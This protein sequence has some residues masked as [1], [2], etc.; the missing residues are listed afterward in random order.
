MQRHSEEVYD[1]EKT[2]EKQK[3]RITQ[4]KTEGDKQFAE[5]GRITEKTIDL[6]HLVLRDRAMMGWEKSAGQKT[7]SLRN[8]NDNDNDTLREVP[9]WS[10]EGPAL[11]ARVSGS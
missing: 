7:Q 1:D 10:D 11:Q 6:V 5:E 2:T 9:H 3:E 8:D 4:F